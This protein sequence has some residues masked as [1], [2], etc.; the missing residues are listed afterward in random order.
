MIGHFTSNKMVTI[1]KKKTKTKMEKNKCWP[2]HGETGT[3]LV[4][5]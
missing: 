2:G 3:L 1:K 4:G 5:M